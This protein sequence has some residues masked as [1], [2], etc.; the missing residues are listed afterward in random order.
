MFLKF[1]QEMI[2]ASVDTAE[3]VKEE[4]S[5]SIYVVIKSKGSEK[6]V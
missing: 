1:Q 4:G 3:M 6:P 2:D 5:V